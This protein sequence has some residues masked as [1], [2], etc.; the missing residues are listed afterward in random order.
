MIKTQD[1]KPTIL[2]DT[3]YILIILQKMMVSM[4]RLN[5]LSMITNLL[6]MSIKT[7][8]P[9]ERSASISAAILTGGSYTKSPGILKGSQ[10]LECR[11][12]HKR[13][14]HERPLVRPPRRSKPAR[15]PCYEIQKDSR[16][17]R[18]SK[19]AT[20]SRACKSR[21]IAVSKRH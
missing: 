15:T 14:R 2:I 20:G 12:I 9:E 17:P 21:R 19:L 18:R 11:V 8:R 7:Y 5:Q 3:I 16:P 1:Q 10:P 4:K 6:T 13:A